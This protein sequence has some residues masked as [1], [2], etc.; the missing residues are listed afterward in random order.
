MWLDKKYIGLL[1]SFLEN[2]KWK[3]DTVANC[4]CPICGDSKKN[5]SKARGYFFPDKKNNNM[6]FYKC[7]NCN[8]SMTLEHFMEKYHSALHEQYML[9]KIQNKIDVKSSIT[10]LPKPIPVVKFSVDMSPYKKINE[11]SPTHEA[12]KYLEKRMMPHEC[13]SRLYF[14]ENFVELAGKIDEKYKN[15]IRENDERIIFP[16]ITKNGIVYGASARTFDPQNDLRYITIKNKE[17]EEKY[18]G[19]ERYNPNK[20][21]YLVEGALD[22][23]FLPNCIASLGAGSMKNKNIPFNI[24][25]T[26]IIYDNEPKN[27]DIVRSMSASILNGFKVCIWPD[28]IQF[29]D[30]NEAIMNGYTR[31]ELIEIIEKNSYF[32]VAGTLKMA[33]WKKC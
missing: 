4:R 12:R 28:Y 2:F 8:I 14:T 29:K 24:D 26:I 27:S 10:E 22:S 17:Y 21:G 30:I 16:L 20:N 33:V 31:D 11:L 9:E 25:K 15:K 3:N 6:Y 32:G 7:W 1:S 18:Y 23:E 5:K 13:F 19:L